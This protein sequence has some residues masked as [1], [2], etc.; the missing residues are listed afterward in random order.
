MKQ[1][2]PMEKKI[3]IIKIEMLELKHVTTK[4]KY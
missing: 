1:K 3:G 2:I 4:M